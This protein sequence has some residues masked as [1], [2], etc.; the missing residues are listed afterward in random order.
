LAAVCEQEQEQHAP[1]EYDAQHALF[2]AQRTFPEN[3][4]SGSI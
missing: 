3:S 4:S 1:E 2:N